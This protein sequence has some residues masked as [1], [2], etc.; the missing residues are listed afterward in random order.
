[1]DMYEV[2]YRTN[3]TIAGCVGFKFIKANNEFQAERKFNELPVMGEFISA[4]KLP[5]YFCK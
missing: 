3:F 2:K 4:K 1:M 5:D